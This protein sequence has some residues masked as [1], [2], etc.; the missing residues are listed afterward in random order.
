M[1]LLRAEA[2]AAAAG[3][4]RLRRPGAGLATKSKRSGGRLPAE[5]RR[6]GV[7]AALE[8][9]SFLSGG[10]EIGALIRAH[11]WSASPIG[12]PEGSPDA[13]RVALGLVLNPPESMFLA[14]GPDL[15]FFF[16]DAYRPI[17]GPRLPYALGAALPELWSDAWEQVRP[18]AEKALAG[19]ASGFD[20]M[21]VT[22]ARYGQE[23]ETWWSFSYSPIRDGSG[24][25]VGLFCITNET[26]ARVRSVA[27]LRESEARWRAIFQNMHE[28]IALCEIVRGPDGEAVDY[29]YLEVNA[30]VERLTA[31]PPAAIV[32]RLASEA[33]PGIERVWT[34]TYARVVETGEPAH[35]EYHLA[36]LGRWFEVYAYRTEPERF[37]VLFLNVTERKASEERQALL[38]REVDHRAKNALAVVQAAL[39][40]TKAPDVP[41]YVRAISGRVGALA[42][43]QTLLAD[44]RWAGADLC[45]LVGGEVAA[46]LGTAEA[47]GPRVELDGPTVALP[48]GVA[49]PLAMAMHE[50]ATNAVKY[51]A[52]SVPAGRVS[53]SW[54][55]FGGPPGTLRLG[56]IE[57]GGP[58]VEGPPDRQGFGSRVLD[59][60]VRGQLGGAVSFDWRRPG[61][62]CDM[63]VPLART[64]AAAEASDAGADPPARPVSTTPLRH[65][66]RLAAPPVV[67]SAP[68]LRR[69]RPPL[70][71]APTLLPSVP[72]LPSSPAFL[73]SGARRGRA[74]YAAHV[75]SAARGRRRPA[76]PA[77]LD[78]QPLR[79]PRRAPA[80]L[81][82]L[83]R[84]GAGAALPLQPP[85]A[86]ATAPCG[87]A[88]RP[89]HRHQPARRADA[90]RLRPLGPGG[91]DR[92]RPFARGRALREPRRAAPRPHPPLGGDL[93]RHGRAGADPL[94][95]RR[96]PHRAR[97][98]HLA[99]APGPAAG[100]GAGAAFLALRP[101]PAGPHRHPRRVLPALRR[102]LPARRHALP[103]VGAR[104]LR[105]GSA[106]AELPR[107]ALGRPAGGPGAA[108]GVTLRAV[109]VPVPATAA[110]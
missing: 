23:E 37:A 58:P 98:R 63:E 53:V 47:G 24:A 50:L 18:I 56:W 100:G 88:L 22:M 41:S 45:T 68:F 110:R 10:G 6:M 16:N 90:L 85:A 42:R 75:R 70:S 66:L 72:P 43:A 12:P 34:D 82:E 79:R 28:G 13:L 14:W 8:G 38:A 29:R 69:S 49:Q 21:P 48:A 67:P 32:G 11:D 102:G 80:R 92:A 27:A 105:R 5:R 15:V 40:L 65:R 25:V 35:F 78:Q 9:R 81:A 64:V 87:R 59:G 89:A 30:A 99:A 4:D 57:A 26:T 33:I 106:A 60:T 61:L 52:L 103:R 91:S 39:R 71:F 93:P 101:C 54:R 97:R 36:V 19:E 2:D 108:P 109:P 46:F 95:V 17:L 83:G 107:A 55:L 7:D 96:R 44:D 84:G 73:P 86:L 62:V 76:R 1:F 20:D 31:I 51:G 104:R 74:A 77:G 94:Q 3:S